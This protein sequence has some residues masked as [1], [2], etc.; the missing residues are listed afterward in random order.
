MAHNEHNVILE[1]VSIIFSNFSGRPGRFNKE[2]ERS[3]TIR[4]DDATADMMMKDGWNVRWL[5]ARSDEETD[6]AVLDI[7][8]MYNR[9][10][11]RVVM[12]TLNGRSTLDEVT[13]ELVD[14]VDILTA[15]ITIR[16]N[17]W[18]VNGKSGRKA[19]LKSMFI[20]LDEDYL[21]RKY[22]ER[23]QEHHAG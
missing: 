16:P 17:D 20:T 11:P 6:Q 12:I 1:D 4:L 22:A 9:R 15:D 14:Q 5:K 3:F 8:V 18:E 2:G 10:P 13:V 7:K 19:Y 21:D 23:E